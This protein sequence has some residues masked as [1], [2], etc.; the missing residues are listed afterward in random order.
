MTRPGANGFTLIEM[1]VS[2]AVLAMTAALLMTGLAGGQSLWQRAGA[3]AADGETV[4]AAQ[5]ILRDRIE[6]VVPVTSFDGS[7]PFADIGGTSQVL[8][9]YG[10]PADRDRPGDLQR[11]RLMLS[12]RGELTL[13]SVDGRTSR[14][15]IKSPAVAGWRAAPL[16]DGVGT[17]E[18]AYYGAAPPDN[19]R[20]W[21]AR[22]QERPQP[23]ELVRLRVVFAPGDR[24]TW[25]DLIIRPATALNSA[26]TID[27][28][29]GRCRGQA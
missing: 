23:P 5:M 24:R 13:Y 28:L 21:R 4:A 22:W 27:P 6:H 17:I 18:L 14:I 1:L 29:T 11:Y 7:A 3:R 2:L 9:F 25:P 15:E 12:P 20:R 8:S 16:L 19:G 26:C 10:P